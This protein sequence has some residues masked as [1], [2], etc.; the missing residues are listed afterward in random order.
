MF[1]RELQ[2]Y[3][4]ILRHSSVKHDHAFQ[5][6][7]DALDDEKE[8]TIG[9]ETQTV[10][11]TSMAATLTF[12]NPYGEFKLSYR[13]SLDYFLTLMCYVT[14]DGQTQRVRW[15]DDYS[16]FTYG[17][18]DERQTVHDFMRAVRDGF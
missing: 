15:W 14:I 8:L 7:I 1:Y 18:T 12:T 16:K 4:S 17:Q 6:I 2:R 3:T 5:D 13:Y 11:P 9:V 10:G